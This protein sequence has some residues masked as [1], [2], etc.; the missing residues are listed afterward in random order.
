MGPIDGHFE[1]LQERHPGATMTALPGTGWIVRVPGVSLPDGWSK[2][3]TE[4]LFIAPQG[5]PFANP[6]CFWTD[7]DLRLANSGIPQSANANTPMPGANEPL[8]WFSWHLQ[9]P[10][11]ASRD[12]FLTWMAVVKQRFARPV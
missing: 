9:Q 12:D 4:V 2:R 7:S 3:S 11:N 5:Y 8:F 1:R 10:W 6:D